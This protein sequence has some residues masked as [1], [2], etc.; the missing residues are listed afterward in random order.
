LLTDWL[1][2]TTKR[3]A[4]PA[5]RTLTLPGGAASAQKDD[6]V[7]ARLRG[8]DGSL[9]YLSA[10]TALAEHV[11]SFAVRNPAGRFVSPTLEGMRAAASAADLG[12]DLRAHAVAAPGDL[13]YPLCSFTFVLVRAGGNDVASRRAAARF[14]WWATHDGQPFAPPLGFGALPGELQVRDEGVLHALRAGDAPAL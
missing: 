9:G 3:W 13:A 4:I 11:P 5:T 8:N 14:L 7:L 6:G 1:S 10:V 12:A 2:R